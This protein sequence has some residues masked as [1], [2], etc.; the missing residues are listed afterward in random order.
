[1]PLT[2]NEV[3]AVAAGT[4]AKM[5]YMSLHTGDPGSTGATEATGG[6]PAYSRQA[7]VMTT[8]AGVGTTT[9]E[10][11][12]VPSGTYTHFGLWSAV[13]GGTFIAG[14]VL[15]AAQTVSVQGQVTVAVTMQVS[16]TG[17]IGLNGATGLWMGPVAS[18]PPTPRDPTVLYVVTGV[19]EAGTAPT[20]TT[21]TLST[22]TVG[23]AFTQ[24]LAAT[25]SSPL[26]W[27]VTAGSL[28]AGLTLTSA[29]ILSGTPTTSGSFGSFTVTASNTTGT[30]TQAYSGT[31]AATATAASMFSFFGAGLEPHSSSSNDYTDGGGTLN[32]GN[33]FYTTQT[34]GIRVMG[35]RVW[36]PPATDTTFLNTDVTVTAYTNDW[37]GSSLN[38]NTT[39]AGAIRQTK[40]QT[41]VRVAGTWTDV[42]FDTPFIL[43]AINAGATG[44]DLLTLMLRFEG[45]TRYTIITLSSTSPINSAV[46][47]GTYLGG[48]DVGRLVNSV[49]SANGATCYGVDVLFE[50]V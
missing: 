31:V 33:R 7:T 49:G 24:T 23:L 6:S 3:Q 26:T 14:D 39:I 9:Q 25:G 20:I 36:N 32:I 45:G 2:P 41:A 34:N 22:M 15:T 17:M 21:T 46:S 50:V 4:A 19:V 29:G 5:V 27:A 48:V 1:M 43:P 16:G 8:S 10:T 12:A 18:L 42:L 35:A 11:F 38:Y 13:T 30:D 47:P 28:P 40:V 37:L 44:L